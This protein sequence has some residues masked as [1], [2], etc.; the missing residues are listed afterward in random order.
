MNETRGIGQV[1]V[2]IMSNRD[3]KIWRPRSYPT[4]SCATDHAEGVHA[5]PFPE[6]EEEEEDFGEIPT[7]IRAVED[8]KAKYSGGRTLIICLDGKCCPALDRKS[9]MMRIDADYGS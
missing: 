8:A 1:Y 9:V 2:F 6:P 4:Q 3:P 5:A 7:I